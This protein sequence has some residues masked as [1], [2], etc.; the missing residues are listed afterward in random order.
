MKIHI[1]GDLVPTVSN[2][3]KFEKD[4]FIDELGKEF[5]NIWLNSDFRVFNLECPLGENLTPI[6]KSG[7]NL[8]APSSTINGIKSLKPNLVCL[9]NNHI[10]DYGLDG[11]ENTLNI[12]SKENISSVGIINNSNEIAKTYYIEKDNIR[13]GIYNVC[14][15]EFSVA[16][17]DSKGANSMHGLKA[18][19]EIH[20]AKQQCDYLIVIYHGGKEFYR[21]PSPELREVCR[22]FVDFGANIVITQH[23]HCIGALDEYNNAKILYGQGNFIFDCTDDE[24]WNTALILELNIDNKGITIKYIPIERYNNVIKI[25]KNK[26]ILKSFENR[27]EEIK[28]ES[29]LEEK[30]INFSMKKLNEYLH[31]CTGVRLYNRILNRFFKRKFF[32]K[33]YKLKDCLAILN[34]IECEAH[35]ELFI[36]GL[37]ERIRKEL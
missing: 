6:A 13:V 23:S 33:K 36:K 32:I 14:E 4:N 8:L 28:D 2:I 1:A 26:D 24:Y 7:P 5:K 19:K 21:Y 9:S 31:I 27:N 3:E 18:Y 37:K 29:L 22:N 34:I 20:N 30:Y 16:T 17:K 10:L 35:R 15:N 11:L 25:S 12:L